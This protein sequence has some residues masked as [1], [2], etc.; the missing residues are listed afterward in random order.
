M[1][2]KRDCGFCG[3]KFE[4]AWLVIEGKTA[5]I[6]IECVALSLEAAVDH[7]RGTESVSIEITPAGEKALKALRKRQ[8]KKRARS[9]T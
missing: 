1:E 4:E 2:G 8:A 7:V 6:C 5:S 3:K 9:K